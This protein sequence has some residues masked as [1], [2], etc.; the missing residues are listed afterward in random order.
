MVQTPQAF[1]FDL[2]SQAHAK[3]FAA[4]RT[5]FPDDATLLEWAGFNIHTFAGEG[6]N[7]KLTQAEDFMRA[8]ALLLAGT[9]DMR[10]GHGYDVH[11]FGPGDHVWLGGVKIAHDRGLVGH[12]DADVGLHALTDALL[13]AL[14]DGDI[15]KL[16][17][18]SDPQWRGAPSHIFLAEAVA[19]LRARGGVISHLD[20]TL[21]CEEPRIGPHRDAMRAEIARICSVSVDRVAV[22]ATTS[23]KLGFTGR[24]EG[25]AAHALAT[26]RLPLRTQA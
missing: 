20:L 10:V 21:V 13:G 8:E 24:G 17:P 7:F 12:S 18:P 26:I 19:R 2:I 22:K 11:A 3:A 1:R 23:E 16:F 4:G 15:G 14:A 25:V 5:D 9:A 6:S